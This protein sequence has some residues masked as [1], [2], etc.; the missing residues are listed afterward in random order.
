MSRFVLDCSVAT[1]WC[2]EDEASPYTEAVLD[3]LSGEEAL[4]PALWPIEMGNVLFEAEQKGRISV[5]QSARLVE[6]LQGLPIVVD[7]VTT[8]RAMDGVLALARE[9]RL[10]AYDA[11][12]L[13][14]ALREGLPLATRSDALLEAAKR[15]GVALV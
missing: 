10:S 11:C 2:F 4:V 5:A 14:L 6:L 1:A 12:Y 15:C 9:H 13:E 3:R 7:H 8:E